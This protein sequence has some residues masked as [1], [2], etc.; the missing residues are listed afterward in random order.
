MSLFKEYWEHLDL[1]TFFSVKHWWNFIIPSEWDDLTFIKNLKPLDPEE[2]SKKPYFFQSNYKHRAR[3][4]SAI[5]FLINVLHTN[6]CKIWALLKKAQV[7]ENS[8]AG[9]CWKQLQ[10]M[11][12]FTVFQFLAVIFFVIKMFPCGSQM[13][14]TSV[15]IYTNN[16]K[17]CIRRKDSVWDI[18]YCAG[19]VF[20]GK[21]P[22]YPV[23]KLW[24]SSN[25]EMLFP[26][27]FVSPNTR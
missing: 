26:H 17:T 18:H 8:W 15:V 21:D 24:G 1:V 14:A 22:L 19:S 5:S 20:A 16:L 23:E 10:K 13:G 12:V 9:S 6:T 25:N 7:K 2:E 4:S 27:C 3:S 11:Q